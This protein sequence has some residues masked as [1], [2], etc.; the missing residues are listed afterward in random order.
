MNW[1][2]YQT[3]IAQIVLR[4]VLDVSGCRCTF[5]HNIASGTDGSLS[6]LFCKYIYRLGPFHWW[7]RPALLLAW[8]ADLFCAHQCNIVGWPCLARQ[9]DVGSNTNSLVA[10]L[11]NH[12]PLPFFTIQG[13][14]SL[15]CCSQDLCNWLPYTPNNT[16]FPFV[17]VCY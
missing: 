16:F 5:M 4:D 11:I 7:F 15:Y 8:V 13:P 2:R 17:S 3:Q 10:R 14:I 9:H 6:V 12:P 1:A